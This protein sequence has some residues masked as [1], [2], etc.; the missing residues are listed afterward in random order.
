M[1]SGVSILVSLAGAMLAATPVA[2]ARDAIHIAR[3]ACGLKDY[4]PDEAWSAR[5]EG[6]DWRAWQS[7][8]HDGDPDA[9]S[10]VTV[11]DIRIDAQTGEVKSCTRRV[12]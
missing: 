7:A 5:R 10:T 2:T 8:P 12:E 1:I 11:I 6:D 9:P 3:Q 4:G